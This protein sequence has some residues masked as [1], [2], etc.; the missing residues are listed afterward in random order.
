MAKK[1]TPGPIKAKVHAT[2]TKQIV[3]AFFD[4]QWM[5]YTNYVPRGKTINA[6]FILESLQRFMTTFKAKKTEIAAGEWFMHWENAPVHTA[7][8]VRN[9][10]NKNNIQLLDNP[11][12]SS[13]LAPADFFLFPKL[14]RELAGITMMQEDFKNKLEGVL[15]TLSKDDFARAFTRWLEHFEKCI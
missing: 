5:V 2:L 6:A 8:S 3:I 14:K 9:I 13:D 11:P 15:R 4:T 12:N 7:K 1:G 10:L